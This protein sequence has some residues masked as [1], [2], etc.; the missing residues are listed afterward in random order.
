MYISANLGKITYMSKFKELMKKMFLYN[1]S[2]NYDFTLLENEEENLNNPPSLSLPNHAIFES[3]KDNITYLQSAYNT[4][5]NSDIILRPFEINIDNKLYSALFVGIDGMVSSNLVNDFLLR[6]LLNTNHY[7]TS[8]SKNMVMKNGV[9]I[10]K[11]KKFNLEDYI[12]NKLVPQNSIKKVSEFSDIITSVNMGDCALF[13]DTLNVAFTIDV[14]GFESRGIETPKNEVVVRGSQEAF[15]EKLRTN[16]SILRRIINSSD[17]I[18]EKSSVGKISK[19]NVAI[20]YMKNIANP[21][22]VAEV[23]YRLNNIDIDYVISS[24]SVR[25]IN[26]R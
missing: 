12:F 17:L 6:P 8:N 14:K 23:K 4:L 5:I 7:T 10:R 26:S 16:T 9:K 20:C 15:V 19:T 13:V 2:S 21:S 11:V 22:L 24:R 3:L 25:T 1:P 18:I